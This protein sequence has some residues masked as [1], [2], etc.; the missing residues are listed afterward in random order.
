MILPDKRPQQSDFA[1]L[2][3]YSLKCPKGLK[4]FFAYIHFVDYSTSL[5]SNIFAATRTAALKIALDHFADCS[6]YVASIN[7][8]GD[9]D[10]TNRRPLSLTEQSVGLLL[11][12]LPDFE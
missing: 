1:N 12:Y 10:W 3:D 7:L 5:L 9:D 8:H 2:T 6:E 11:V 4:R